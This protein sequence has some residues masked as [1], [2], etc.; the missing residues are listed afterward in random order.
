[1][2]RKYAVAR[3]IILPFFIFTIAVVVGSAQ[4]ATPPDTMILKGNPMGAV[5]FDHKAHSQT[6][7]EGKCETC[8]HPSKPQK[9]ATAPQQACR[10]CHTKPAK[11]PMKTA[12]QA[13][14]HNPMA[15]SG[16]CIDCHLKMNAAGKKAPTTCMQCH[17][18]SN[19]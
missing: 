18:K 7:A 4:Q 12:T 14:F 19:G 8:H 10:D 11:P 16:T 1:M 2:S 15:K 3:F 9:A 6:Y 5:K 17:K 13:A